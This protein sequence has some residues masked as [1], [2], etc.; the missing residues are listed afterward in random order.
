MPP[1]NE[2]SYYWALIVEPKV[3]KDKSGEMS[4]GT[5]YHAKERLDG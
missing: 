2:F 3:E 1:D 4:K 5:Q